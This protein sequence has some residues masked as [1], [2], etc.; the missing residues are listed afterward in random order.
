MQHSH[1]LF[2]TG[3]FPPLTSVNWARNNWLIICQPELWFQYE[4]VA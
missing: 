3:L 1:K 2:K 4:I